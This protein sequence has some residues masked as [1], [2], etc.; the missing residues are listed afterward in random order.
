[1]PSISTTMSEIYYPE[2]AAFYEQHC[3]P[4]FEHCHDTNYR[5]FMIREYAEWLY[6]MNEVIRIWE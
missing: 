1:M 4:E 5:F 6:D 2:A 3:D